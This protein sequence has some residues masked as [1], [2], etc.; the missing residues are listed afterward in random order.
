MPHK[1]GCQDHLGSLVVFPAIPAGLQTNA[2]SASTRK[3]RQLVSSRKGRR[4][5]PKAP[6][7]GPAHPRHAPTHPARPAAP[8]PPG[9][10]PRPT[11]NHHTP[12]SVIPRHSFSRPPIVTSLLHPTPFPSSKIQLPPNDTLPHYP[13]KM[14][15]CRVRLLFIR[16]NRPFSRQSTYPTARL[17]CII[18]GEVVNR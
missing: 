11:P 2:N 7:P 1:E 15:F 17:L 5:T 14:I 12:H 13:W 8:S 4:A 16:I 9:P 10:S 18:E 3:T 6:K